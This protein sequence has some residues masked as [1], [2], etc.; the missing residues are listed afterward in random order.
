MTFA[1]GKIA[2]G[3]INGKIV[4][5]ARQMNGGDQ[6]GRFVIVMSQGNL[7]GWGVF[8]VIFDPA[9]PHGETLLFIAAIKGFR[10]FFH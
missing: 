1:T 3:L 4:F 5:R 10:F 6:P 7:T 9:A 8:T 2:P